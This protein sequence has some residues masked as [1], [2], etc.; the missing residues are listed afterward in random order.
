MDNSND[1]I[2]D[3]VDKPEDWPVNAKEYKLERIEKAL[4]DY[5][6]NPGYKTKEVLISLISDYDLNQRDNRGLFRVTDY[7]VST[8]NELYLRGLMLQIPSVR[9]FVYEIV[10]ETT[11]LQKNL[12]Y[13]MEANE[14]KGTFVIPA[15]EK[16]LWNSLK[17]YYFIYQ[18]FTLEKDKS[19]A[20][21]T[22]EIVED[23]IKQ[24]EIMD[25]TE[26]EKELSYFEI[27]KS[28]TTMFNDISYFH[29][30]K[31]EDIW[32]FNRKELLSL[33]SLENTLIRLSHQNPSERPLFGVLMTQISNYILKSRNNYNQDPICKYVSRK[34]SSLSFQNHQI[35]MNKI[36]NLNDEREGHLL[37]ELFLDNDREKPNWACNIDFTPTRKYYVSSF[38]KSIDNAHMKEEYGEVVFGFKND[39]IT[40]LISPITHAELRKNDESDRELPDKKS[41]YP[42]SLVTA[43]DVIYDKDELKKEM[44]YLF[45]VIDLFEMSDKGKHSFLESILQYWLLSA[46]DPKWSEERERRYVLFLYDEYEY[47]EME[48][49][50]DFLKLNTSVFLTPDF[51]MG[52]HYYKKGIREQIDNKRI[53]ISSKPYLFCHNCFNRDYDAVA[54]CNQPNKCPVCGSKEYEIV[55]PGKKSN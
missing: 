46:K 19:F 47:I 24:I 28:F 49:S 7:E 15:Y 31:N 27:S 38:A 34:N 21:K 39:R 20:S 55:I 48:E 17:L 35:W 10:G 12:A 25:S 51:L 41:I 44:V 9:C 16:G 40:E 13:I 4:N 3:Y 5:E 37:Q 52:N 14:E 2:F 54:G 42:F 11:R 22:V 1:T 32:K 36:E 45:K 29:G 43:Y 53:S 18:A 30:N 23:I 50:N 8:L 6:D 33:F 26:E